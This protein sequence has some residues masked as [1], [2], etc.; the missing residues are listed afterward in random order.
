VHGA[1]TVNVYALDGPSAGAL[2]GTTRFAAGVQAAVNS[3]EC[4]EGEM[5]FRLEVAGD[6][7]GEGGDD[8]DG[9]DGDGEGV[10]FL[11]GGV[12]GMGLGMRYGC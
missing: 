1:A 3:F 7:D 5:C 11:Q 10:E 6:G 12:V 9:G 4:G 8:D 2:V